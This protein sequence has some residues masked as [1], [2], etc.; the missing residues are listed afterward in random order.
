[1]NH[2]ATLAAS[3]LSTMEEKTRAGW[4]NPTLFDRSVPTPLYHQLYMAL[5]QKILS[6]QLASEASFMGEQEL[7]A[8]LGVSR[9]T[10]KRALKELSDDGLITRQRGRG[11]F[12]APGRVL[13]VVSGSFENL[14]E[15]LHAM[16]AETAVRLVDVAETPADESVAER[17]RLQPGAPV[18]RAVRL[19]RLG[20][21]PFSYLTTFVPL[22]ISRRYSKEELA[23]T[24]M[25]TLLERAGLAAQEAEQWITAIAAPPHIA[26][27]LGVNVGAP[28]LTIER[29]LR[30][31]DGQ[32]IQY[33]QGYY[34][35]D[36]FR[37]HIVQR[38][39]SRRKRSL[40]AT[41]R[42]S[43]HKSS[44]KAR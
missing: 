13:P 24:P 41:G 27:A 31:P 23:S 30:G 8:R 5:R 10:V 21:E 35:P 26:A 14:I 15:S 1:M 2:H 3:E 25:L 7:S 39:R 22:D 19:R 38:S 43:N 28:L 9:I 37:Y 16:G 12:V 4:L 44:A 29:V 42:S 34:H 18:Q 17:L 40:A 11:T 33:M 6:G 36:R 32:P 20:G